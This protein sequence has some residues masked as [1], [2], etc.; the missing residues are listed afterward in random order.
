MTRQQ[1]IAQL[2]RR[3]ATAIAGRKR[4]EANVI[5][6]QLRALKNKQL[7]AEIR[8]DRKRAA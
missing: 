7:R 3:Y 6:G 8:Q 4:K 2:E 5:Y 1:M